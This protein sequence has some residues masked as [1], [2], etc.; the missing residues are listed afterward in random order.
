MTGAIG[1]G[2]ETNDGDVPVLVKNLRDVWSLR[3]RIAVIFLLAGGS[4][5]LAMTGKNS[6]LT[7]IMRMSKC[8]LLL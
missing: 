4:F 7:N 2:R 3:F 1:V 6:L 5:G 8:P